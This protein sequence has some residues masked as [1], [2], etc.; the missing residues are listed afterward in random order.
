LKNALRA[1]LLF[2]AAALMGFAAAINAFLSVPHLREDMAE[3][4]VRP[5]LLAAVSAGLYFGAFA[6]FG[7]AL[8]VLGAAVRA[9]RGEPVPR[10]PLAIIAAVYLAF[11]AGALLAWSRSPHT[12]G[13]LFAG[14]LIAVA[15]APGGS[16]EAAPS[17]PVRDVST[18]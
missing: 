3:I 15:A 17:R 10:L 14:L 4:A 5:T 12:L 11:G 18:G 6:M 7:F 16:P 9:A 1:T 2:L 13:Y 8:L